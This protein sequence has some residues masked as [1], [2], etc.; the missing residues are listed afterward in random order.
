M[1]RLGAEASEETGCLAYDPTVHLPYEPLP[2]RLP[3]EGLRGKRLV[4]L[5]DAQQQLI[6]LD[7]STRQVEDG[8]AIEA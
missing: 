8:L 6:A 1:G 5:H 3:D 7:A 2:L 4:P